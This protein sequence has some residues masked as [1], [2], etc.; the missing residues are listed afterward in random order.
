MAFD[1]GLSLLGAALGGGKDEQTTTQTN[2][3][4]APATPYMLRG[5]QD[6]EKLGNYYKQNP[7]NQQQT[8]SYS[9]LF[10]DIGNFRNNIAPGLM[11]A[12]NR[13]MNTNYERARGGR[14]GDVAGYGGAHVPRHVNQG[15]LGPFSVAGGGSSGGSG[16]LLDLN[17]AQN[18]FANGGV[19]QNPQTVNE[20]MID[21]LKQELG[22]TG[23]AGNDSGDNQGNMGNGGSAFNTNAP[24]MPG[25]MSLV[26]PAFVKAYDAM[27]RSGFNASPEF[28]T[29]QKFGTQ[30]WRDAVNA[31]AKSRAARQGGDG[32]GYGLTGD[33]GD[34]QGDYGLGGGLGLGPAYGDIGG[35]GDV[36]D[37]FGFGAGDYAD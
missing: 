12:A 14:P 27:M 10:G 30:A 4:W 36:G 20:Q 9:N 32:G 8:Q 29:N 3:P 23:S 21:E 18:P 34:V 13:G 33:Y 17:G 22:L 37:G 15:L 35:F 31:Y 16:G 7:F 19:Q 2:S 24:E 25:W 28:M 1:L 5:L 6:T 11:Q 26:S